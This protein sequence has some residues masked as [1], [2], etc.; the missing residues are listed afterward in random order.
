MVARPSN[1]CSFEPISNCLPVVRSVLA[2]AAANVAG[3]GP[4]KC[5]GPLCAGLDRLV[6]DLILI[7]TPELEHMLAFDQGEMI[8]RRERAQDCLGARNETQRR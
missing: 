6:F 7:E 3:E 1:S 8:L 5:K 2:R 4:V